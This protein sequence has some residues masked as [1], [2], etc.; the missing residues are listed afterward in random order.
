MV[1]RHLYDDL[2]DDFKR[3]TVINAPAG[4]YDYVVGSTGAHQ[5]L[6][7]QREDK[8]LG[9][10]DRQAAERVMQAMLQMSKIDIAALE[11]AFR[12]A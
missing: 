9:D 7:V 2:P 5:Y 6:S 4:K 1:Y 12:G 10:S 3:A 11:A 8:L